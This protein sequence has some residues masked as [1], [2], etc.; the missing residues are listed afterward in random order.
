MG[1]SHVPYSH[2][3]GRTSA[4]HSVRLHDLPFPSRA[5]PTPRIRACVT[6][7]GGAFDVIIKAFYDVPGACFFKVGG[8]KPV[9]LL[10]ESFLY[11]I[12]E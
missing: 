1:S 8:F 10:F 3:T 2:E 11:E 12:F 4:E 6:N 9:N 5:C 7:G